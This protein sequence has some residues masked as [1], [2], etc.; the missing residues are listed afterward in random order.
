MNESVWTKYYSAKDKLQKSTEDVYLARKEVPKFLCDQ[1]LET[2]QKSVF[3]STIAKGKVSFT[4]GF[5]KALAAFI[6][7]N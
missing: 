2:L 3:I 1:H 7:L 5:V 4:S 6:K